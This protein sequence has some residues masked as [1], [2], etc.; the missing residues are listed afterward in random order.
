MNQE[1]LVA[2]VEKASTLRERLNGGFISIE[3]EENEHQSTLIAKR[4]EEWL[5][6]VGAQDEQELL[7]TVNTQLPRDEVQRLLG[8]VRLRDR[9]ILP[10]WA[11]VLD[12]TIQSILE[13]ADRQTSFQG[14]MLNS[15]KPYPFE[16]LFMPVLEMAYVKLEQ[17]VPNLSTLYTTEA[18]ADLLERLLAELSELCG[19][20]LMA[21]F[22]VYRTIKFPNHGFMAAFMNVSSTVAYT[23]YI[24]SMRD[25]RIVDFF[26][27]YSFLA[28][29]TAIRIQYWLSSASDLSRS[30]AEDSEGLSARYEVF[31]PV[32]RL[33]WGLS[34]SHQQGR[35]V[36]IL[37]YKEQRKVV[38]KPKSLAIDQAFGHLIEW[39]HERAVPVKF[40]APKVWDR[41]RY[42][43]AE[44]IDNTSCS[45][46]SG[47]E[48][49]YRHFGGLVCLVYL[50][51]GNDFH[52][53]NIVAASDIPVLIDLETLLHPLWSKPP[54]LLEEEREKDDAEYQELM[55]SVFATNLL[56]YHK[57]GRSGLLGWR[58]QEGS[59]SKLQWDHINLDN[60]QVVQMIREPVRISANLPCWDSQVQQVHS[61]I[62]ELLDGFRQT[63][64]FI[65]QNKE[66]LLCDKVMEP[67]RDVLG[68][69]L[70]RSTFKYQILLNKI[71]HPENLRDGL[72]ASIKLETLSRIYISDHV[73]QLLPVIH[74]EV[75]QLLRGDIPYFTIPAHSRQFVVGVEEEQPD[76]SKLLVTQS[77]L[78]RLL[79]RLEQWSESDIE[80]QL[81]MMEEAVKGAIM[82]PEVAQ[83]MS[84]IEPKPPIKPS[85]LL[86]TTDTLRDLVWKLAD[87]IRGRS[88]YRPEHSPIWLVPGIE[89]SSQSFRF[90]PIGYGL[91]DGVMGVSLFLMAA[92]KVLGDDDFTQ[93][94]LELVAPVRKMVVTEGVSFRSLG[95]GAASG[96]ASIV[97]GLTQLG[98]LSGDIQMLEQ[99]AQAARFIVPEQIA[100][101]GQLD[102]MYGSAGVIASLL[103]LYNET[104]YE[105]LL[106]LA[107]CAGEQLLLLRKRTHTG[108]LAWVNRDQ[109]L[110]LTGFS[111]GTAGISYALLRLYEGTGLERYKEAA[112]EGLRYET[113]VFQTES[114][115]WP[116]YRG[117]HK[118]DGHSR[119]MNSWC[120]GAAGIGLARMGISG[121][122]ESDSLRQDVEAAVLAVTKDGESA[123]DHICCGNFGRIEL[124]ITASQKLNR[125][126]LAGIAFDKAYLSLY[127]RAD[128]LG[129]AF[130]S[131]PKSPKVEPAHDIGFHR[132]I[133]GIGYTLLRL[134]AVL[135]SKEPVPQI[136]LWN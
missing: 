30:L 61:F 6:Y 41:G 91:Y 26:T 48:A 104:K 62:P 116:D 103:T 90:H 99:A 65:L 29:L 18:R 78:E 71:R 54:R 1:E 12:E 68:R 111:H 131:S 11:Q 67:F 73:P 115:N 110:A 31:G 5:R 49:Y 58:Q 76:D 59:I 47:I 92:G 43:W 80:H 40:R 84:M 24:E 8:D 85:P 16:D 119:F 35:T 38:Y 120:N 74:T 113:A 17:E 45:D 96:W 107:K 79:T 105:W 28:R 124:L 2:I 95:M 21:D 97:Y 87:Y 122:L 72:A 89:M 46:V 34:D 81:G 86:Q 42:G 15:H 98:K 66:Q 23:A 100:Q 126:E 106:E 112:E 60:M 3:L 25:G 70:F 133:A 102:M 114:N 77:S 37:E 44:Y 93:L 134:C 57:L 64:L 117:V 7:K 55:K 19:R 36:A 128:S 109:R 51:G 101:D 10:E 53:E 88:F 121:I 20:A 83:S 22:A 9:G 52:E 129:F 39:L 4:W 69:F 108:H 136:L 123:L 27:Q 125:P 13:K 63:A 33:Q 132:G 118:L 127:G 56:P 14:S 82:D 75:E 135:E 94:S 50:L 32:E 130:S